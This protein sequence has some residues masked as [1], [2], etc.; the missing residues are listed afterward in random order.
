MQTLS[1]DKVAVYVNYAKKY[2]R[3]HRRVVW[4]KGKKLCQTRKMPKQHN[5]T[6]S[7]VELE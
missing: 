4:K 6:H 1:D 2:L 3:E 5:D 7:M